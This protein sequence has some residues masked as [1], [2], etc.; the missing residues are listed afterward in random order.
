MY[1]FALQLAFKVI[2]PYVFAAIV[3]VVSEAVAVPVYPVTD[4]PENVYPLLSGFVIVTVCDD[5]FVVYFVG[6]T[7]PPEPL[8]LFTVI[9]YSFP[10]QLAFKVIFP[11]VFAAIVRVVPETV[12]EPS[13]LYPATVQLENVYPFFVGFVIVTV[14]ADVS[15]W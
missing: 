7:A 11:Y 14:C 10:V 1:V 5:A 8:L 15:I 9:E 13:V 6:F 4:Q 2:F 12:A 3:S